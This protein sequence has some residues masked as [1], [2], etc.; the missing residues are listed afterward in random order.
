YSL[1]YPAAG[2]PW[3]PDPKLAGLI[4]DAYIQWPHIYMAAKKPPKKPKHAP[5]GPAVNPPSVDYFHLEMP[6]DVPAQLNASAV[7][8][9][10]ITGK[11]VR[12]VMVDSG[13]AH[14][15]HPFFAANGFQSTVD[16]A[17]NAINDKTDPNGHGTGESTNI[18][19]VAPGATFIGV[20]VDNDNDPQG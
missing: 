15:S 3:K 7:H 2:A 17:P 6:Q 12:V 13:F 8:R 20:K 11:G 14:G 1:Y 9:A 10:G 4:D 5:A 16:L 18:F 19:A